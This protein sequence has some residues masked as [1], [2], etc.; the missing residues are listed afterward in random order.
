V[1]VAIVGSGGIAAIHARLIGE[2]GGNLVAV[3]SRT[4][5]GSQAFGRA[6]PYDDL[7]AMLRIEKPDVVH[8]C[9]PNAFHAEHSIAAFE[10]G[11]HVVCEKPLATSTHDALRMIAAA[12]KAQRIGAVAYTYRGYPLI[13]ELR[14]AI[15]SGRYGALRRIS[16][17]YLSQDVFD[18][19]SY[20]WHF[21][22]G[23][24]GSS[25]VLL[26]YGVHWLDLVEHVTGQAI[27]EIFALLSTH[28]NRRIWR[29]GPGQGPPPAGEKQADGSVRV[30][31][32]LED[33][34]EIIIRLSGGAGGSATMTPLSAGNANRLVLSVD[35]EIS[36]FDWSQED[37]DVFVE[38]STGQKS[39]R[40]RDPARLPQEFK[41]MTLTPPGHPEGYFDA[42]RNVIAASWA[43]IRGE[44]VEYPTFDEGLRG[45]TLIEA[46]LQSARE[47]RLV[48]TA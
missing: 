15:R 41:W 32:S 33:H 3:C 43:A 39:R 9:T 13:Q 35:G 8:V 37:P 46:A 21:T 31:F 7:A 14:A 28:Q 6:T 22:P 38:R 20:Q 17:E 36:G 5:A 11:A 10:A 2:L 25:Y 12:E 27:I 30:R 26:D 16:G 34:V 4:L 1:R 40:Y 29:G 19:S 18:P 24:T 44:S 48:S 47:G 42:F 45:L 23:M